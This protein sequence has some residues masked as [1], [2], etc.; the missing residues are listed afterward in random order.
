M[1][2][3]TRPNRGGYLRPFG[4]GIFIRDFLRGLGPFGSLKIDPGKGACQEDIFYHY[5]LALHRAYARDSTEK[6]I[7]RLTKKNLWAAMV[8]RRAEE[9][10][11]SEADADAE[12]AEEIERR[13]FE[14]IPYKLVKARFHSF[15]RYFH[16]LKQLKWVELTG[17]EE[18]SVLQDVTG[19]HPDAHP[20]KLYRL[21]RE[22]VRATDE[23][24][25]N[26]QRLIYTLIGEEDIEDYLREKRKEHKYR[27]PGKY[28]HFLRPFTAGQFIRDY[29]MGLGPEDS[30]K[31]DPDEGDY[32]EHIFYHY[33]EALRRAYARDAVAREN[34]RRIQKKEEPYTPEEYAERLEWHLERITYKL[35]RARSISF[36]RYFHFL[37]QLEFVEFTGRE[38]ESYIQS[39][40]YPDAPPCRYYRLSAKGKAAPEH[41]WYRPQLTLYPEF[42]PEYYAQK[43]LERRQSVAVHLA[44]QT[45]EYSKA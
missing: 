26:P 6:E 38:E 33:K 8:G 40:T 13:H 36:F 1:A 37:K 24:W 31:I 30:L 5:K 4:C 23:D 2:V 7:E 32:T 12:L 44:Y 41:E 25:S 39:I 3:N 14:R 16:Y 9:K 22:G 11:I 42:T 35:H 18:V 10:D 19:H 20:R 21:T 27:R 28:E 29:L 45:D 43:N 34:D 17:E 15:R